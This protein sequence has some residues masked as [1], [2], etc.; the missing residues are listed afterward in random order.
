MRTTFDFQFIHLACSLSSKYHFLQCIFSIAPLIWPAQWY[1]CRLLWVNPSFQLVWVS[2]LR[3]YKMFWHDWLVPS[4]VSYFRILIPVL[5]SACALLFPLLGYL[6]YLL[7]S[8]SKLFSWS[9]L[10]TSWLR[11]EVCHSAFLSFFQCCRVLQI[12]ILQVS[13]QFV[14]D[15]ELEMPEFMLCLLTFCSSDQ[16]NKIN[17][18]LFWKWIN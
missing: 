16:I 18:S 6:L 8:L 5:S 7:Y 13:S 10:S 12:S 14:F 15:Q 9:F 1:F 11:V 2:C 3:S 4:A 17:R